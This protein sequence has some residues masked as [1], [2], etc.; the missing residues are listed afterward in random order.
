M[1][2]QSLL[3]PPAPP[4]T[5]RRP[6]LIL[7]IIL[8]CQLMLILDATV[9]NVALP[10]IQAELGFSRTGLS[11]VMNAYSL[12]FGG[13]L[14]LGGRAGDLF[15]RRRMFVIGTSVF[16]VASLAGGLATSAE[17]L[18]VARIA[19]GVG[20]AMAGPSTL[21]LIATTFTEPKARMRALA[22]FSAMASGGFAI[23]LILGGLLT[24]WF[25]WRAVLFINVPF[26]AAIALLAPK[27]VPE[28][29]RRRAHL[30]LPGAITGTA[31]VASLVYGFIRAAQEGWGDAL[32][33]VALAAGLTLIATFL[34]I[35]R[36]ARQPLMP[37][38]LFADRNRA[39]AYANFFFGPMAMMSMFFFLTQFLQDV[40]HFSALATGFAFLPMA[41]VLFTVTRL[42]S[43]LLPKLGPK[44]MA[45]AG[46]AAMVVGLTWLTQL[47]PESHYA[48]G[49]LAPMILM[50]FGAGFAFSPLNILIMGTV[51]AEDAGAAGGVLQTLQQGGATLG[52][53]ILVTVFGEATRGIGGGPETILVTGMTTAFI[54][55]ALIAAC[56]FAVAMTFRASDRP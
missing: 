52:L 22:L 42:V 56:T 2:E 31:G 43:R 38:R 12:V 7:A 51:P 26:G 55:S 8:T 13:F 5:R 23:G 18:I 45:A 16:T 6:A 53:A 40:S 4:E 54:A 46:T 50:G 35:E 29:E 1:T 24:Q 44:K 49:M 47:T 30:D 28:P 19:Q 3:S 41:A 14:L 11:W 34:T 10:P 15:G 27:F 37:L 25:T 32:T 48:T 39:A 9:M 36:R 33:I 17:L 21:A 20:A